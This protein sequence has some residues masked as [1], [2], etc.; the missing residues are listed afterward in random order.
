[1]NTASASA[2]VQLDSIYNN[3]LPAQQL[4]TF[5]KGLAREI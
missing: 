2:I 4:G 3:G 5:E 1:L